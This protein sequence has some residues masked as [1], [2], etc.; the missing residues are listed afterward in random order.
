[1]SVQPRTAGSSTSSHHCRKLVGVVDSAVRGSALSM[2]GQLIALLPASVAARFV[3]PQ[4][5]YRPVP[6]ALPATLAVAWP[7]SSRSLAT[8]AFV[9]VITELAAGTSP[10]GRSSIT[11]TMMAP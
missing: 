10:A 2:L 7:R 4:L 3:R 11:S 9:R 1:V 8:A 5:T 6:D